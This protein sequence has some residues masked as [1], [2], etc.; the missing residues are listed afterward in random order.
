M[1][2]AKVDDTYISCH[3][4][5]KAALKAIMEYEGFTDKQIRKAFDEGMDI[6][7]VDPSYQIH[8]TVR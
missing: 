1:Y 5:R 4:T 7:A 3:K 6:T 8:E 2:I